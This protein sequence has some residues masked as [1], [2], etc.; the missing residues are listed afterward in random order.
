MRQENIQRQSTQVD[1]GDVIE[2]V[3]RNEL[4]DEVEVHSDTNVNGVED[5]TEHP[6]VTNV[7]DATID[8]IE[9]E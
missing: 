8:D 1:E 6:I 4:L 9:N 7:Q 3:T 5:E 2:S